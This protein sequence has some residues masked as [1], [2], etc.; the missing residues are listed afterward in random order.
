MRA[1]LMLRRLI[2]DIVNDERF[3]VSPHIDL[4]SLLD[5]SRRR[6]LWRRLPEIL[7]T[8]PTSLRRPAL[9]RRTLAATCVCLHI[10]AIALASVDWQVLPPTLFL[11]AVLSILLD[12]ATSRYRYMPPAGWS[13]VAEIVYRI[14]GTIAANSDVP[15]CS[16]QSVLRELQPVISEVLGQTFKGTEGKNRL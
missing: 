1:F 4:A 2:R 11:A 5:H 8:P 6:Q 3:R 10:I 12:L 15:L 7:G 16:E 14:A 9:L 13:S